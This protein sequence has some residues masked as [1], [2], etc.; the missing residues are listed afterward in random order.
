MTLPRNVGRY[1]IIEEIGRGSMGV[2][3]RARDPRIGRIVALKCVAFSFP[4][5]PGEEQE[6]L[7]RFYHEAQIAGRLSHP[8]IVTIHDVGTLDSDGHAFMAMEYVTG[9][10]LQEHLAGGGRLP[11]PQIA[12]VARQ[13]AEALDY[14]HGCGVVHRDIKPGNLVLA[15]AGTLKILDFGIARIATANSTKPGR[16]LGTPNYMAPEQVTGLPV[17]GRADQFSLAVTLYHLLTGERPFTGESLTAISYQVVNITPPPPSRLNPGVPASVDPVLSRAMS[18]IA[19]DRY[20]TCTEFASDLSQA[21]AAWKE[22][23]DRDAPRTLVTAAS[24]IDPGVVGSLPGAGRFAPGSQRALIGWG[25]VVAVLGLVAAAPY[26]LKGTTRPTA[27]AASPLATPS[28]AST[29]PPARSTPPP[30]PSHAASVTG[31]PSTPEV[32]GLFGFAP[33]PPPPPIKPAPAPVVPHGSLVI[34][35]VH[36]I[37]RGTLN[38]RVDD[39]EVARETFTGRN[40]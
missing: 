10:N 34:E 16:L 31:A 5:A 15:E 8:N 33:L 27:V 17:D 38:L 40:G 29:D 1:E 11:F 3:Y 18:K 28:V 22:A 12:A 24:R 7:A 20:P 37:D 35:L 13:A 9:I 25:M 14:A 19:G 30:A 2:V 4:L 21:L 39:Q 26:L 36:R 32:R 23:A 6:F